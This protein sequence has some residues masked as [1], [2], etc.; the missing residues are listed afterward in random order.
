MEDSM[1][2]SLLMQMYKRIDSF[3]E[4]GLLDNKF[5]V[6]FGSN[7][8]AE[9]IM[10]YL[11]TK[12]I[13]VNGLVDNNKKKDGI[14]LNGVMVTLPD[15]LLLPKRDNA[16]IF[17]ASKYYPEM[18]VQ[19]NGMGY[20]EGTEILKA[21]EYSSFSAPVLTEDEFEKRYNTVLDGE[22]VYKRITEKQPGLQ[23]IFVCP[24]T[25]LGDAYA[26]MSC[27]EE[28]ME[29]CGITE[30][31]LVLV[32]RA[33]A[34]IASLFGFE[35]H[36]CP[37]TA[38]EME[39][40]VQYAVFSNMADGRIL[41]L[42]HRHPY[43]CRIGEIGNYKNINF[44][45]HFRYSIFGL[46]EGSLPKVPDAARDSKESR[47]YVEQLF[48]ENGLVKGKTVI[49]FPY[50]KTA[51][52]LDDIFWIKL[53]EKLKE[54][55]YVVCTNSSGENEPAIEGT[56]PLFFDI[57]YALETAGEAGCVIG[58]R[59][60]LCDVISTAKAKKIIIYPD[61]FYGPGSF[62][63]FFSLVNMGL[64]EDAVELVWKGGVDRMLELILAGAG[65]SQAG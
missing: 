24:L 19:L 43:T 18:V 36:I 21:V 41:I 56:K 1:E 37:V 38:E 10:E 16:V 53:A 31:A 62:L 13:Q 4:Q 34:K 22:K 33:C 29:R 14:Y 54:Q 40:F 12:N 45:D 32:N 57:R 23:K 63:D 26:G 2:H 44:M 28:Y 50:A 60:G 64:C 11:E 5:I 6:V 15:K 52:K 58:L 61:R 7:E 42:N 9:R 39:V 47:Q 27:M 35:D 51:A 8:P 55:G 17:I 20:K 59:S 46:P 65:F 25:V 48:N 30:Y 49:L 3:K